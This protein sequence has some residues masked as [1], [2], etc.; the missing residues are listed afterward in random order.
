MGDRIEEDPN[1]EQTLKRSFSRKYAI[2]DDIRLETIKSFMTDNGFLII[3]VELF[4][5]LL[6]EDFRGIER[7]GERR[8]SASISTHIT[9]RQATSKE[10]IIIP[11]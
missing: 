9:P 2:P 3:R 8:R 1:A 10:L 7:P 6:I 4:C 5:E 11:I